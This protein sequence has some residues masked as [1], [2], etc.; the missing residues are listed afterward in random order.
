[1]NQILLGVSLNTF[2]EK[3]NFEGK[4]FKARQKYRIF[5]TTMDAMIEKV[6]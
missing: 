3:F 5:G 6:S 2:G 1:M 4:I